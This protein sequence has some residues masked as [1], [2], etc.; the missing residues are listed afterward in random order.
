MTAA[1]AAVSTAVADFLES[2]RREVA[3]QIVESK[4]SAVHSGEF[5]RFRRRSC[6]CKEKNEEEKVFR[7]AATVV[8][9]QQQQIEVLSF[10][11]PCRKGMEKNNKSQAASRKIHA[12]RSPREEEAVFV[13][14]TSQREER[15]RHNEK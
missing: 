15:S 13:S 4:G 11:L 2:S 9:L 14:P 12:H 10:S 8:P 6:H 5:F 1:P 3:V 7:A